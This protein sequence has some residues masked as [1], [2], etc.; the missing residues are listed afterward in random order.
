MVRHLKLFHFAFDCFLYVPLK[1][2]KEKF[3]IKTKQ[4]G[5]SENMACS[6]YSDL[7]CK[8]CANY[9]NLRINLKCSQILTNN[10][11]LNYFIF[12]LK[13]THSSLSVF[14][15]SLGEF[16]SNFTSELLDIVSLSLCFVS[17]HEDWRRSSRV[18]WR[19]KLFFYLPKGKKKKNKSHVLICIATI[20]LW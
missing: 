1:Y 20:N 13:L 19:R 11:Y 15:S 12:F 7:I 5:N 6:A 14:S 16:G 10:S 9:T 2:R 17:R 8:T 18:A 4:L 3:V